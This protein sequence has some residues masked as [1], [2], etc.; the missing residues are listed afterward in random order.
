MERQIVR[1][2]GN[3]D[4]HKGADTKTFINR[5]LA[6]ISKATKSLRIKIERNKKGREGFILF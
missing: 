6:N 4:W 1:K 5:T 2:Y 3:C